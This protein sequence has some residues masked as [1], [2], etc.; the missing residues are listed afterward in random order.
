M[1]SCASASSTLRSSAA[2]ISSG[3]TQPG[4]ATSMVWWAPGGSVLLLKSCKPLS[5]EA[6]GNTDKRRPDPSVDERHFAVD[7][8]SCNEI[9]GRAKTVENGEDL[10]AG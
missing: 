6:V 7:Q 3:G 5:G 8:A 9:P 10:A 1:G 4:N 2:A